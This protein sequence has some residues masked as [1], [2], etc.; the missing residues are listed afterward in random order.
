[1]FL[2]LYIG[3]VKGVIFEQ[4]FMKLTVAMG[5]ELMQILQQSDVQEGEGTFIREIRQYAA[6]QELDEMV[7]EPPNQSD[8]GRRG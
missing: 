2:S 4:R 3:K 7:L 8:S 1:M 6:I 5:Q